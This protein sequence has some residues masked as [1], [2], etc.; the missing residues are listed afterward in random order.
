MKLPLATGA[1]VASAIYDAD[2]VPVCIIDS[3]QE[4]S[5]SDET[6]MARRIV[7]CVNAC[8]G[9]PTEALQGVNLQEKLT[10][11]DGIFKRALLL[12][13]GYCSQRDELLASTEFFVN[14]HLAHCSDEQTCFTCGSEQ[15]KAARAAIARVKGPTFAEMGG[16]C[17]CDVCGF[18]WLEGDESGEHTCK[19]G[20]A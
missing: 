7:A 10:A 16:V 3:M 15:F 9:I 5:R 13:D 2:G 20:A 8:D 12:A 11:V 18:T 17:R 14:A 6:D 1:K 19:G 4:A